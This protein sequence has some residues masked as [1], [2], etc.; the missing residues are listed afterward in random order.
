MRPLSLD[1]LRDAPVLGVVA[2]V[3]IALVV[4]ARMLRGAH[5]DL[6]R[7]PRVGE[8]ARTVAAREIVDDCD[9]LLRSLDDYRGPDER[10]SDPDDIDWPF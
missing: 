7:A 6:D 5:P 10:G 1:D 8:P 3:E 4:L 9:L 2:V